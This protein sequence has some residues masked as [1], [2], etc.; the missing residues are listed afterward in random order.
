VNEVDLLSAEG[1]RFSLFAALRTIERND[2]KGRRIGVSRQLRDDPVRIA[3]PP[4]LAFAPTEVAEIERGPFEQRLSQYVFGFLGPNGPLPL[5]ITEL[6]YSRVHQSTDSTLPDFLDALQHR[7]ATLFYRAW[8]DAEATVSAESPDRDRFAEQIHALFGQ[9]SASD[10]RYH[11]AVSA[12]HAG[13]LAI[14]NKPAAALEALLEDAFDVPFGI[15]EF[16]GEWLPIPA[17][18]TLRLGAA[19]EFN[20]LGVSSTIGAESWQRASAFELTAGPLTLDDF[21]RFLPGSA[22]LATLR[23]LVGAFTHR[24]WNWR[25]RLLLKPQHASPTRL[26]CGQRLGLTSWLGARLG[27]SDDVVINGDPLA[28]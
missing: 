25:I 6:A 5:H 24:Q 12:R 3:Q 26:G 9:D 27:I 22:S 1:H 15:V 2:P 8:A 7:I 16:A 11:A 13:L 21:E 18:S 14:Q 23:K 10:G 28:R 17:D 4:Y 20:T 19:P